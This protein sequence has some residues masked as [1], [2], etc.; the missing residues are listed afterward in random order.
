MHPCEPAIP[1]AGD[2]GP[3]PAPVLR[4]LGW[5]REGSAPLL[6]SFHESLNRLSC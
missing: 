1:S 2:W 6:Y 4:G 3:R 5:L